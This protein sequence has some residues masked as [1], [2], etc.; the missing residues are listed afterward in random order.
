M[1]ARRRPIPVGP[2]GIWITTDMTHFERW[3]TAEEIE[4]W[5]REFFAEVLR[6]LPPTTGKVLSP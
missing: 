5:H 3:V 4:K 6:G 2:G 1:V